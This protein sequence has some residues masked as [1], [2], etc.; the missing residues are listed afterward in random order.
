MKGKI[1]WLIDT[2][3]RAALYNELITSEL[4]SNIIEIIANYS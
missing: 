4:V 2:I 1:F 3:V